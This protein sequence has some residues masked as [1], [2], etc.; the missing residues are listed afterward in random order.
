MMKFDNMESDRARHVGVGLVVSND[1]ESV[2]VVWDGVSHT[3][4]CVYEI[5][6]LNELVISRLRNALVDLE[7]DRSP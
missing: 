6:L 2:C 4:F 1:R 5:R 7:L 3:R